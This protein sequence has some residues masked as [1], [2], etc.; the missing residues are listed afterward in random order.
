M[1]RTLTPLYGIV[2][3]A[4]VLVGGAEARADH[5]NPLEGKPAI[6]HKKEL[7]KLRFEATPQFVFSLNQVFRQFVGG[8]IVLQFHITDWL[9]VAAQVAGGGSVDTALT[10]NIVSVLPTDPNDPNRAP[11]QPTLQQFRDHL[12][13]IAAQFSFYATLTPIAGKMSIFGAA[14][15]HY[16]VYGLIG[17]GGLYLSNN[18][19]NSN[20][21]P[22]GQAHV[23]ECLDPNTPMGE[24]G[25]GTRS[26]NTCDPQNSG[27]K[28]GGVFGIGAH[29]FFNDYLALNLEVRDFLVKSNPGGLEV[30]NDPNRIL[31]GNDERLGNNLFV[32]VGL[33]IMLPFTAK[34]SQ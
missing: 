34:I 9:G 31:D 29:L 11:F 7:R 27:V 26:P 17:I 5:K 33:T 14:F 23:T 1:R 10:S 20:A 12:A 19:Q 6:M 15:I 18:F 16:D 13:D 3:L 22:T 4:G 24:S 2:L 30:D 25:L 21:E 8:G 28:F 32:G